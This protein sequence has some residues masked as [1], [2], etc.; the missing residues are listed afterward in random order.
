MASQP[1]AGLVERP[2]DLFRRTKR[3][4]LFYFR[5]IGRQY[6]VQLLVCILI[7]LI[8]LFIL[9]T[10]IFARFEYIFL[11][12][13]FRQR[14]AQPVHPDIAYI[15]IAEDSIQA[16]GRWPWP[17]QYHAVMTHILTQWKAK[18]VVFDI[19]F[20][21]PSTEL[22]DG[23]LK[24]AFQASNQ[25]YLSVALEQKGNE[26]TWIHSLHDFEQYARGTGHINVQPDR[27]GTVRRVRPY[28]EQNNE[29][30]PYLA[31]R[32]AYD[33]LGTPEKSS[34]W[35]KSD[36][37]LINWAGKWD[38]TFKHYSYVDL[39]K[40]FEAVQNGQTPIIFPSE[41]EGKICL[42]GLTAFGHSDIKA[43]PMEPAYPGVGVHANIIN[44]ILTN[45]FI[46]SAS[47][48]TNALCLIIVGLLA[49]G[50]FVIFRSVQ[51]LI[52]GLLIGLIWTF[53]AYFSFA[54]YGL[55]FYAIQPLAL[56]ISLYVF[57]TVYVL[58]LRNRERLRLFKLATHDG[59]T[60]LY[61][62]RHFRFLLNEAVQEFHKRKK[63]LSVVLGDVDFFKKVNDTYG[64]ACGDMVLKE[65]AAL[66][67][68]SI[69]DEKPEIE[70]H[71]AARYGGEEFIVMLRNFNL[72]DAAFKF[73][74][75]LR[76]EIENRELI[77][78]GKPIKV[79]ISLGVS[80]LHVGEKVPDL[81]VH[82]ADSALYRAKEEG[83]NRVCIEDFQKKSA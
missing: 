2:E 33:F 59:L 49:S 9:S 60:G 75:S 32:V 58:I 55:W 15:E 27:D 66:I 52:G 36:E 19:L 21:E 54:H 63:P 20:S 64:H 25:V 83:R 39:I 43:T 40:S 45:R 8:H 10:P 23:A 53:A 5:F 72:S 56:I 65:V 44:S 3:E 7:I 34:I 37:L 29:I 79:T 61:V 68:A 57:S 31:L 28:L 77:W 16:I 11:D 70:K 6:L 4:A 46:Y 38:K 17:R 80:T 18:A 35:K 51:G 78:D 47:F 12:Y 81:M 30:Q 73:A 71:V 74:E 14:P 67:Q 69:A 82:R 13:F 1:P 50:L 24:E 62:I 22:D 76:K 41:I 42:I 48:K 26:K